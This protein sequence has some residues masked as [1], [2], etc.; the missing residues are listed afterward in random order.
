MSEEGTTESDQKKKPLSLKRQGGSGGG[1]SSDAGQVRQS[2]SHG[3]SRSVA[4]EVRKKRSIK[5]GASTTAAAPK[6]HST[7]TFKAAAPIDADIDTA[8]KVEE[9]ERGAP[10]S[11]VV[12]RTLTQEEKE[13]R[14]RAVESA[15]K[16][17]GRKRQEAEKDAALRAQ[18]DESRAA[19]REIAERR[20]AEEASRR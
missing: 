18:E 5:A 20:A 14:A 2:F 15:V 4:V 8:A 3:R 13:T 16:E 12:L 7:G 11:R 17:E 1:Q 6:K 19:E 9:T 10:K